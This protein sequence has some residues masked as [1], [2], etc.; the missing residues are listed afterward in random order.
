V[1][2]YQLDIILDNRL[3]TNQG[4][5]SGQRSVS[6]LGDFETPEQGIP[7]AP[8]IDKFGNPIPWETCLTL[9]NNWGYAES[10]KNWKSPELVI[11]SLVNCVSKNG[12]MLL[13]VGPDARGNIPDESVRILAEV[14]KW[15]AD[16]GESIYGSG[17]CV[18]AKPDW[19]RYSRNGNTIYAHWMYPNLGQLNAKGVAADKVKNV[20][21]LKSGAEL[22]FR[23]TW[24]GNNE[25][26]NFFINVGS[27]PEKPVKY[28][29]VVKIELEKQE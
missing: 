1:R 15:M 20:S 10:D 27:S 14:G 8:I 11:H 17:A 3:E 26:G 6:F 2:K 25:T 23:T 12:N 24:W 22:P 29:T 21:F 9:N 28:D 7:E 4:S 5:A 16:N 18:L 19:G 13:N